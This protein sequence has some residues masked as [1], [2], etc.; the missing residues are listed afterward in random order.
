M[1][2]LGSPTRERRREEAQDCRTPGRS[3]GELIPSLEPGG[4]RHGIDGRYQLVWCDG[5]GRWM[6]PAGTRW[7]RC[8][9]AWRSGMV[10]R[11]VQPPIIPSSPVA[12]LPNG[13]PSSLPSSLLS[14]R[15]LRPRPG[16]G[17]S[18]SLVVD[19]RAL[20]PSSSCSAPCPRA[21]PAACDACCPSFY[22]HLSR[23]PP[24]CRPSSAMPTRRP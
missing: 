9:G 21:V 1:T 22:I 15:C 16:P 8:G 24:P 7:P 20:R 11:N 2:S 13:P 6:L 23:Q 19:R 4:K 18:R 3:L 12:T 10:S 14:P 5:E 17:A